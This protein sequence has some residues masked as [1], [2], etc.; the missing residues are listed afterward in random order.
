MKLHKMKPQ[1]SQ[2][3]NLF[4][5]AGTARAMQQLMK[6]SEMVDLAIIVDTQVFNSF[7]S[8]IQQKFRNICINA[9]HF[10]KSN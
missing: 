4:Q 1:N 6:R 5:F 8:Q 3:S 9:E 10:Q 7:Y 2:K